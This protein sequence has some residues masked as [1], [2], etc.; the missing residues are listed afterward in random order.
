[1]QRTATIESPIGRIKVT[2]TR[3][4]VVEIRLRARKK[5]PISRS[6]D[7]AAEH[8]RRA[9]RQLREYF[10]GRRAVFDVPLDLSSGTPFQRRVWRAC[11]S[12]PYGEVRSYGE[13]ARMA[14]CPRG[15]RAVGQVMGSNPVPLVVPCHR[16][17]RSDGSLGGF[18]S[19]LWVK[20]RLLRIEGV[21]GCLGGS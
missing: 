13:L 17:I 7:R 6:R 14:G 11:A 10:A 9:C 16:V 18:G 4:G 20:R 8:L 3:R 12:I 19:G 21:K 5:A 2:T 1:V 15:A